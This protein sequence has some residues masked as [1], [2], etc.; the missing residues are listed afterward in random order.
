MRLLEDV[1][2]ERKLFNFIRVRA[3]D[4]NMAKARRTKSYIPCFALLY[5]F[6]THFTNIFLFFFIVVS[7]D[8]ID[9][10]EDERKKILKYSS[11]YDMIVI[12]LEWTN[13]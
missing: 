10:L 1:E 4:K 5:P 13:R 11:V 6:E 7:V 8:K 3:I 9:L 2:I 12:D